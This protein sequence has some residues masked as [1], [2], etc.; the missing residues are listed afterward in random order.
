MLTGYSDQLSVAPSERVAF[1]V[2]SESE[3]D[4]GI[5]R[6]IQGDDTADGPGY[7]EL[8]VAAACNGRY[9]AKAQ[10]TN[11]G[12]YV[13]VDDTATP[14][15]AA[16][17]TFLAWVW[18]TNPR[19]ARQGILTRYAADGSGYGLEIVDGSASFTV[20]VGETVLQARADMPLIKDWWHLVAGGY[21][22]ES[23]RLFVCQ[24]AHD[25]TKR[26]PTATPVTLRHEP[27]EPAWY[28]VAPLLIAAAADGGAASSFFNGRI[29]APRWFGR[30]LDP[31]EIA[32]VASD[33]ELGTLRSSLCGAWDLSP[34]QP[35]TLV[36]DRSGHGRHGTAVN[37]PARAVRGHL[38]DGSALNATDAP[39][40]YDCMHFHDDDL[41]DA[42]W[43]TNAVFEVPRELP[44]GVYAA[45]LRTGDEEDY[46]PFVV[47][48][49]R[50]A[51]AR[52]VFV[53]PTLSYIAYGNEH[54]YNAPFVDWPQFSDRPLQLDK[55]DLKIQQHPEFGPSLYDVHSDGSYTIY[56][57]RLRPILNLRPKIVAYWS[58]AGRHFGADLY[59]LGWLHREN[60]AVDVVTD[61]DLH[62]DG[63]DLLAPYDVV[64]TGNHPEYTTEPMVDALAEYAATGGH[65]MYLGGNGFVWVT[66]LDPTAPHILEVR[67]IT[68]VNVIPG[69]APMPGEEHHSQTGTRGGYW[70]AR[71]RGSENWLGIGSSAQGFAHASPYLRTE[72]SYD[73]QVSWI[74]DGVDGKEIG[75]SGLGLGGAAGDEMDCASDVLGTPVGTV[76]LASSHDHGP[77]YRATYDIVGLAASRC[78]ADMT[79][80]E[81]PDGGAVFA[82]G[83]MCWYPSLAHNNYDNDVARVTRNVLTRFLQPRA[84]Q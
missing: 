15:P 13:L 58:G 19:P 41:A 69:V 56:S 38:W 6:L 75:A 7:L 59:M 30:A 52:A 80:L 28:G 25:A 83:S 23:G 35:S 11:P 1:K 9:P 49:G 43:E 53:L 51:T 17:V 68:G 74:F 27:V 60:V 73:P 48:P 79:Y 39:A 22:A 66:T 33:G 64:I 37:N 8:D 63:I 21:D 34:A 4:L 82:V 32:R 44:S 47:R 29:A 20:R 84:A 65:I 77:P 10:R 3:F 72:S 26:P 67:K 24:V 61:E 78:R 36:V 62:R 2:N 71:G 46:L 54:F 18:P 12:S 55:A 50:E 70:K 5:V 16:G 31:N 76:V 14:L 40:H 57:S 45:R 42:G 81:L